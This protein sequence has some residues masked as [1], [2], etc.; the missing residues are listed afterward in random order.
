MVLKCFI[1][2]SYDPKKQSLY[3]IPNRNEDYSGRWRLWLKILN[4]KEINLNKIRICSE[5]FL[6]SN[7]YYN[8]LQTILTTTVGWVGLK[9]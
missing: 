2:K 3:R 6:S 1:C 7:F 5:H 4:E 9:I 8:F